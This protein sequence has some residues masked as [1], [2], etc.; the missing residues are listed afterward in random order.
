MSGET[1]GT[2]PAVPHARRRPSANVV[3]DARV[4]AEV[5]KC[6]KESKSAFMAQWHYLSHIDGKI[7]GQAPEED[8]PS[9][10]GVMGGWM[11]CVGTD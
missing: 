2:W 11:T 5:R 3:F 7:R 4:R 10:D 6:R 9:H 1:R 8:N